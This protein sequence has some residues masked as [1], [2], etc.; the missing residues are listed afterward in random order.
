MR[1]AIVHRILL[2]GL[3]AAGMLLAGCNNLLLNTEGADPEKMGTLAMTFLVPKYN[4]LSTARAVTPRV[5]DPSTEEV[6]LLLNDAEYSTVDFATLEPTATPIPDSDIYSAFTYQAEV[7]ARSYDTI[8]LHLLDVH[9]EVV[10]AG[11]AEGPHVI[12]EDESL[13][14]TVYC[15]PVKYAVLPPA[16]AIDGSVAAY[17]MR[18]YSHE[19]AVGNEY[20]ITLTGTGVVGYVFD[21]VG[22]FMATTISGTYTNTVGTDADGVYYVGVYNTGATEQPFTVKI[23]IAGAAPNLDYALINEVLIGHPNMLEIYNPTASPLDIN[24]YKLVVRRKWE[25]EWWSHTDEWHYYLFSDVP[26]PG[27]SYVVAAGE[28]WNYDWEER[29]S[30]DKSIIT[31]HEGWSGGDWAGEFTEWSVIHE[32]GPT[33]RFDLADEFGANYDWKDHLFGFRDYGAGPTVTL[34]PDRTKILISG[35]AERG[36]GPRRTGVFSATGTIQGTPVVVDSSLAQVDYDSVHIR[37]PD[38]AGNVIEISFNHYSTGPGATYTDGEIAS[39]S[40]IAFTIGSNLIQA[41]LGEYDRSVGTG[42]LTI[43]QSDGLRLEGSFDVTSV[44]GDT[45]NGSFDVAGPDAAF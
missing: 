45:L 38:A 1:K 20:T 9:G 39:G 32:Y 25:D 6:R 23:D 26:I 16:L 28:L 19:L 13:A 2:L 27:E 41:A 8:G 44:D 40:S 11:E 10:T 17:S 18:Y 14:L 3:V 4:A 35:R 12:T 31:V 43:V 34:S 5:I 24:G 42:S 30:L 29:S 36:S 33:A 15:V 21:P 7:P 37:A 22:Q